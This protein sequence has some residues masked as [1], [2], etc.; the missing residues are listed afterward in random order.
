MPK[1]LD[2]ERCFL[3][4]FGDKPK[5]HPVAI[6]SKK[7]SPVEMN[8]VKFTLK[9]MYP[10]LEGAVHPF[11]IFTDHKNLEYLK[12]AKSLNS[13]HAQWALF[14][15]W[16]NFTLSYWHGSMNTKADSLS[17]LHPSTDK[18]PS[19]EII[20]PSS[21]FVGTITW[22]LEE[23]LCRIHSFHMI[24]G[25]QVR[26]TQ[27]ERYSHHQSTHNTS[28]WVSG[29]PK[30]LTSVDHL[31]ST[32][33]L[34][35]SPIITGSSPH[36]QFVPTLKCHVCCSALTHTSTVLVPHSHRF[37]HW[38]PRPESDSNIVIM[39]IINRFCRIRI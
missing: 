24:C 20:L 27:S 33:G 1:S 25:V 2:S 21:C 30:T 12:T 36:A 32:C 8:Y 6:N 17:H 5:L 10:W 28:Y 37:H 14:F 23:V 26:T 31:Q 13:C 16:F 22:D 15:T 34:P 7:L 38:P 29:G 3:K 19:P 39:I 18:D 9:V 4:R 35:W 11:M